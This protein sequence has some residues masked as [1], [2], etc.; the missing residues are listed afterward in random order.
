M[1]ARRV[2][3]TLLSGLRVIAAGVLIVTGA[4]WLSVGGTAQ[5]QSQ[6]PGPNKPEVLSVQPIAENEAS[7]TK[8]NNPE[9]SLDKKAADAS[10]SPEQEGQS[11]TAP[12]TPTLPVVSPTVR[13]VKA[14]ANQAI[15]QQSAEEVVEKIEERQAPVSASRTP[16]AIGSSFLSG[17]YDCNIFWGGGRNYPFRP[18]IVS[19]YADWADYDTLALSIDNALRYDP[20]YVL[21]SL[22][23]FTSAG[24]SGSALTDTAGGKND[25]ILQ[26]LAATLRAYDDRRI[27]V[28]WAQEMELIQS[29]PWSGQSPANYTAAWRYMV[30]YLRKAGLG[31]ITWMWSPAGN[32]N[33]QSYYPGASFV[34]VVG[35]TLLSYD[36]WHKQYNYGG[37][38]TF[39]TLFSEKYR[40]VAGLGKPIIIAE[41]GVA[42]ASSMKNDSN[43]TAL[44]NRWMDDALGD[45]PQY[46]LLVGSVYFNCENP[47]NFTNTVPD[48]RLVDLDA[49]WS[50]NE[51]AGL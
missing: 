47:P 10:T 18:A 44:K 17:V 49:L 42:A 39:M 12:P 43:I 11:K 21:L 45:L 7:D 50:P 31:D 27:M 3:P 46:P 33:A 34:D 40:N 14:P 32:N 26:G 5:R 19:V 16:V 38:G 25:I 22:E 41:L 37:D 9:E 51:T 2:S 36:D 48:W 15:F 20:D 1:F 13:V 8:D 4:A 35:L 24:G 30:S 6:V 29:F 28:R 23:P